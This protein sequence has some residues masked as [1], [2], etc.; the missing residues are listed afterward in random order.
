M[1]ETIKNISLKNLYHNP[2]NPRRNIGDITEL[3]DSI[4]A[5]GILQNLTVVPYDPAIHLGLTV[6]DPDNAFVVLIGNRRLAAGKKAKVETAPCVVMDLTAA[7][8]MSVMLIENMQREDLTYKEEALGFQM[9]LD[10]GSTVDEVA[11]MT[12]VSAPTVRSR[13]RLLELDQDKLEKAEKRGANL[14][15]YKK[16]YEIKD[17]A[18]RDEVLDSIGTPNFKNDLKRAKDKEKALEAQEEKLR[19]VQA[20][21]TQIESRSENMKNVASYYS[22][23]TKEIVRPDDADTVP[24]F[25]S[26]IGGN[27]YIYREKHADE[28]AEEQRKA[29]LKET[30]EA[31]ESKLNALHKRFKTLRE[32]FILELSPA[33]AR[34]LFGEVAFF[35]I[36]Q[37]QNVLGS[38]WSLNA[39][40]TK[41]RIARFMDLSCDDQGDVDEAAYQEFIRKN[42]EYAL[43]LYGYMIA[44]Q[45]SGKYFKTRWDSKLGV[46][47]PEYV[48]DDDLDNL[49]GVLAKLGY[50][51][52]DEEKQLQNGDHPLFADLQPAASAA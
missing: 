49:Y 44:E 39:T 43:L 46:S 38:Y 27:I 30:V 45:R 47:L 29:Q 21:A 50:V 13:I 6:K 25:Y 26:N 51:M 16:L 48:A 7:K 33:K 18:L 4:A 42:P 22:W 1:N 20:F 28:T 34:K 14:S 31:C 10:L 11:Q 12:G 2:N 23:E 32:D 24:Y 5:M 41:K 19:S 8:Q 52:S 36:S 9:M 37:V 3:A 15:D 35:S 40:A 17:P